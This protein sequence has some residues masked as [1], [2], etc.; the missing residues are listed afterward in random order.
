MQGEV[1]WK[2]EWMQKMQVNISWVYRVCIY[3]CIYIY[4]YIV[5][6][7]RMW[8]GSSHLVSWSFKRSEFPGHIYHPMPCVWQ[9]LSFHPWHLCPCRAFQTEAGKPARFTV[10]LSWL[11]ADLP[12]YDNG[13]ENAL[14]ITRLSNR[15]WM[16]QLSWYTHIF[17]PLEIIYIYIS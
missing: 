2:C 4:P 11:A 12:S 8:K 10:K 16:F 1:T 9:S 14:V 17:S 7:N 6:Y 15:C 13:F 3:M 5:L